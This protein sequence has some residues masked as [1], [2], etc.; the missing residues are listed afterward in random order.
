MFVVNISPLHFSLNLDL[1][2]L[3]GKHKGQGDILDQCREIHY[4]KRIYKEENCKMQ[5]SPESIHA[6]VQVTLVSTSY[7]Q[8]KKRYRLLINGIYGITLH[9]DSERIN[10]G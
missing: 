3:H 10:L 4:T 7:L 8:R 9:T 1:Q 2:Q 6:Q 5:L